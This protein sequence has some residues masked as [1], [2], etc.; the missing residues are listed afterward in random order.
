MPLPKPKWTGTR[1]LWS[2]RPTI[3]L[4]LLI[5][6]FMGS[7]VVLDL[8]MVKMPDSWWSLWTETY[9]FTWAWHHVGIQYPITP[10]YIQSMILWPIVPSL[11]FICIAHSTEINWPLLQQCY[12]E[13]DWWT[14]KAE[15]RQFWLWA[16]NTLEESLHLPH[17]QSLL[18][19]KGKWLRVCRVYQVGLVTGCVC[20]APCILCKPGCH[21]VGSIF[22]T[23]HIIYV[24]QNQI[25]YSLSSNDIHRLSVHVYVHTYMCIYFYAH[26]VYIW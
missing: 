26:A 19:H 18:C 21:D 22:L 9:T 20:Y 3:R 11:F 25:A 6:L 12:L 16:G 8:A 15:W 7:R 10:L 23:E 13:Q 17:S 1:S 4:L 14:G 2:N 5:L 24:S